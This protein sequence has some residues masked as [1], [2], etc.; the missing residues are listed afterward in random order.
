[1]YVCDIDRDRDCKATSVVASRAWYYAIENGVYSQSL[2]VIVK[3]LV[4]FVTLTTFPSNLGAIVEL[5]QH[6]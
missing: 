1:M 2:V 3:S 5:G 4:S 6:Q